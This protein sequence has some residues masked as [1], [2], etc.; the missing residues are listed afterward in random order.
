[1]RCRKR[2]SSQN[3]REYEIDTERN[4]EEDSYSNQRGSHLF[5]W[6]TE[7]INLRE[8]TAEDPNETPVEEE[9]MSDTEAE[10]ELDSEL[11]VTILHGK[12]G[13]LNWK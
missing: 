13:L 9:G 1:M 12:S 5:R 7:D 3:E 2:L 10:N 6:D 11:S 4:A 8:D